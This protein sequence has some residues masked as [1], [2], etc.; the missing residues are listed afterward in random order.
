LAKERRVDQEAFNDVLS[1]LRDNAHEFVNVASSRVG[2]LQGDDIQELSKQFSAHA[3]DLLDTVINMVSVAPDLINR[4]VAGRDT[5][6]PNDP[7]QPEPGPRATKA[8]AK[9]PA[10][11]AA[12]RSGTAKRTTRKATAKK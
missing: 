5:Q 11:K 2:E 9:A 7:S 12:A 1:R 10:R 8:A 4:L 6:G 3:Q